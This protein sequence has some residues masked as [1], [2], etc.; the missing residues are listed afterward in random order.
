MT[1]QELLERIQAKLG[2]PWQSQR[3]DGYA[4]GFLYGDPES[5]ITGVVTTYFPSLDVLRQAVQRGSNV[6]I[7]R[8]H[9]LFSRGEHSPLYFRQGPVPAKE[10]IDS[11]VVFQNKLSFIQENHLVLIRLM[12]NWDARPNSTQLKALAHAIGWEKYHQPSSIHLHEWD[13]RN[14]HFKVPEMT[15]DGLGHSLAKKLNNDV[16]RVVGRKTAMVRNVAL[17][18][19][20]VLVSDVERIFTEAKPDVLICGDVVEWEVGPYFQDLV[21]AKMAEGLILLG[22]EATEE[23]GCAEMASWLGDLV[24][25]VPVAWISSGQPFW[26]LNQERSNA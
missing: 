22:M 21:T 8:E 20:M 14:V 15:L 10:A 16:V 6:I 4:D 26:T 17:M 9:P 7:C 11:D 19:G 13:P 2:I 3:P 12:D 18:P 1:S 23:P 24:G 25:G 5:Q